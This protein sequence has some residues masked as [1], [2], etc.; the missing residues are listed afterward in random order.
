MKYNL[1]ENSFISVHGNVSLSIEDVENIIDSTTTSGVVT[2]SGTNNDIFFIESDLGDRIAIDQVRYYFDSA[3]TSGVVA[4]GIEFYYKDDDATGSGIVNEYLGL[5]TNIGDGY[6]YTTVPTPSAPRYIRLIHT[7]SGTSITGDVVGLSV[8]NDDSVVDFGSDG[9]L[10]STAV[11]TSLSYLDYNDYIREIEIYNDGSEL[12]TAYIMLEPQLNDAD[13]LMSVSASENGPWTSTRANDMVVVDGNLWDTGN[14]NNTTSSGA[15]LG[16]AG[17][18]TIGTYTTHIFKKDFSKFANINVNETTVSGAIVATDAEDYTSTIEIRSNNTMPLGFSSYKRFSVTNPH[19][20]VEDRYVE[21]DVKYYDMWEDD[22]YGFDL[23]P[24]S[25]D[26]SNYYQYAI[27]VDDESFDFVTIVHG[28]Y[29]NYS[30]PLLLIKCGGPGNY[31]NIVKSY[32]K[33]AYTEHGSGDSMDYGLETYFMKLD[34]DG[35][36]WLYI[37]INSYTY[38]YGGY[39]ID[40]VG[41]YLLKYDTDM[42]LEYKYKQSSDFIT[43]LDVDYSTGYL[44]YI[45]VG[46]VN[47]VYKLDTDG[48]TLKSYTGEYATD[49][50]GLCANDDGGCWIINGDNL[51]RLD[52]DANVIDSIL[53]VGISNLHLVAQDINEDDYLW[54]ADGLYVKRIVIADGRTIFSV[55]VDSSI[56]QLIPKYAGVWVMCDRWGSDAAARFIGKSSAAE[57]KEI[58]FDN[59]GYS[60]PGVSQAVYDNLVKGSEIPRSDDP[61]WNSSLGWNKINPNTYILPRETHH[62]IKLTLRRPDTSI[63]SPTIDDIYLQDSVEIA[64]IYPGQ[65][66]TLYLKISIPDGVNVGGD[67]SSMLRVWWEIPVN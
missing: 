32:K 45:P 67:Y 63:D 48:T 19:G 8:L 30:H 22:S 1:L 57:E 49:L 29:T 23:A 65:S 59:S 33:I 61:V 39:D 5:T 14:Y 37:Y 11:L 56:E 64:D 35:G 13:V 9:A 34:N 31:E 58:S 47:G 18:Q 17:G 27:W 55:N 60:V 53:N 20:H 52:S 7:V 3:T 25:T 43:G 44:W 26:L 28:Y 66:K 4:S 51:Y 10:E 16:L 46:G 42:V 2:I 21:T 6:Y 40:G 38:G 36:T 62:Q 54:I 50:K 12:A 15:K 24:V 41:Y